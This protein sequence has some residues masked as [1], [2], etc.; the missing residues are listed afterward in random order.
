MADHISDIILI[1]TD[2]CLHPDTCC[3]DPALLSQH[4]WGGLRY[5]VVIWRP[6]ISPVA[7][8]TPSSSSRRAVHGYSESAH[9]VPRILNVLSRN[10]KFNL[11]LLKNSVLPWDD[12][13]PFFFFFFKFW[14]QT[15]LQ[16]L[17][18]QQSGHLQIAAV[19]NDF[20]HKFIPVNLGNS[21]QF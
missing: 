19:L 18:Q 16:S 3:G 11:S 7:L 15:S 1:A 10:R 13:V 6:R 12:F 5:E 14:F 4:N 8:L 9:P 2:G 20:S 21:T 17:A